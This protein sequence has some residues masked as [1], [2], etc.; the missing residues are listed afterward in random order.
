MKEKL[1]RI[2]AHPF[3]KYAWVGGLFSVCNVVLLWLMIDILEIPTIISSTIVVGVLFVA[4][5][6]AYKLT[7]FAG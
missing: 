4:K 5:Y 6:F 1:F 3:F 7:G 2:K